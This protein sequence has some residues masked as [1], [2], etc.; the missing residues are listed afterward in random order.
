MKIAHGLLSAQPKNTWSIWDKTHTLI[1]IV[2]KI[3]IQ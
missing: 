3:A 2:L 1:N